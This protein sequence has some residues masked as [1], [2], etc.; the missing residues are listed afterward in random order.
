MNAAAP[1]TSLRFRLPGLWISFDPRDEEEIR[2]QVEK[3]AREV[4]GP[5]DDAAVLRRRVRDGL[6]DAA[7]AARAA[8]AH[9]LLMCRE[10]APGVSTPVSLSVHTPVPVTPAVGTTPDR[11]LAAFEAALPHTAE[12]D[13]ETA[14]RVPAAAGEAVRL[15]ALTPQVIEEGGQS[16]TRMRLVARYWLPVPGAKQVVLVNVTTPLG[17][18]PHAMLR[19]FDAMLAGAY[20]G[21]AASSGA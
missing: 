15:H 18:I 6:E 10:V 13:L 9:L 17:D 20:W 14:V 1:A 11:V 7:A 16:I 21:G 3:I 8:S 12:P 19:L 4:V 5:A 2:G